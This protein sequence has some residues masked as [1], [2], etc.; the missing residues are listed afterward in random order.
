MVEKFRYYEQQYLSNIVTV[1]YNTWHNL[2][3]GSMACR[4]T[5]NYDPTGA[6]GWLNILPWRKSVYIKNQGLNNDNTIS[7]QAEVFF[8]NYTVEKFTAWWVVQGTAIPV[9]LKPYALSYNSTTNVFTVDTNGDIAFTTGAT[10][11]HA[12]VELPPFGTTAANVSDHSYITARLINVTSVGGNVYTFKLA[13][14]DNQIRDMLVNNSLLAYQNNA[15]WHGPTFYQYK[16]N[17]PTIQRGIILDVGE[18]YSADLTYDI[19][20]WYRAITSS[21]V[22]VTLAI[23]QL[24]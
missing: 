21:D 3:F 24:A 18:S 23:Q 9:A 19:C 5:G 4:R 2:T 15:S 13:A 6:G 1:D 7:V 17:T 11:N 20:I 16:I 14:A 10:P 12:Y 8:N 22:G